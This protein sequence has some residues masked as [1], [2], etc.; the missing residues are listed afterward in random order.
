MMPEPQTAREA[1]LAFLSAHPGEWHT[2]RDIVSGCCRLDSEGQWGAV[3][4]ARGL[5]Y[6]RPAQYVYQM[7]LGK[8]I[9]VGAVLR[10]W[11]CPECGVNRYRFRKGKA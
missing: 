8:L 6:S 4:V 7:A 3:G 5:G 1:I 11:P 9:K 10:R 2:L